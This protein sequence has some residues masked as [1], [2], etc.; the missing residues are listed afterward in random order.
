VRFLIDESADARL[1]AHLAKLGR[2][3][4]TVADDYS[5]G[6]SDEEVLAV[7]R[8]ERRILITD[9]SDFGELVFRHRHPHAG[10]IYFRLGT[11]L[12]ARRLERLED[13]LRRFPVA[14][15]DFLVVTLTGIRVGTM[16]SD[17]PT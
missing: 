8:A 13:V 6:L 17:E 5:P 2:G 4:M 10:G 15:D 1:A 9:D 11:T 3:V 16:E 12:L 14:L 7:A